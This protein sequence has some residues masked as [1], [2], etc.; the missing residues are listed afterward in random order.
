METK[1]EVLEGDRAKVTVTIDEATIAKR[2]KS[3]YKKVANQYTIPGFRRGKAPRP[4]I[5]SA[6]GK[7]YVRAV[8]TDEIVNESYPLAIDEAGIFPVGQPDFK[9]EEG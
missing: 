8:V 9:E 1:V 7:D 2:I 3:Q 6:L 5:D 4:V